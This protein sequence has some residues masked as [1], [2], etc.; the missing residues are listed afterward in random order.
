MRIFSALIL[1]T[2]LMSSAAAD[3]ASSPIVDASDADVASTFDY[4]A[5]TDASLN[6][7]LDG[8]EVQAIASGQY[9]NLYMAEAEDGGA[10]G[11]ETGTERMIKAG[12]THGFN[13]GRVDAHAPIGVM[14]E[15]VHK[16]GDFMLSYRFM[17]MQMEGNREG[18][19]RLSDQ[20]VRD[21][22]FPVVPTD[23][24]M[25][26]HMFGLMFA[27]TDDVTLMLMVPYVRL[28]MD[29][30]AG[31]TLGDVKFTTE[32]E[33]IGDIKLASLIKLY[34][35]DHRQ[36][37]INVGL[38]LPTGQINERGR[39][40]PPGNV[41]LPYP[42]QIG[43]G[44]VDLLLAGTYVY[45]QD[46]WSVGTQANGV[47]RLNENYR[48]YTLGNRFELTGWFQYQLL[49]QLSASLRLDYNLWG[50]IDGADPALNPAQVPTA[51]PGRRGGQRLDLLLGANWQ[52]TDGCLKGHRLAIEG[53]I[54]VWQ[55][56]DGPQL[57]VTWLM[58]VGWQFAF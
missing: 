40:T 28:A 45:Q 24:T 18:N 56:L 32:S 15:H 33:G 48:D 35:V 14:G 42:M 23:M 22:G 19:D 49:E 54:P 30:K 55:R 36:F 31:A 4:L 58:T 34:R 20:E 44:T 27:P 13:T 41:I 16:A 43:S 53:G 39:S 26:M 50:N 1:S 7:E 12:H 38:S 3:F 47:I 57:E 5:A 11:E 21:R 6:L 2:F 51:D 52:F 10:D 37:H 8:P 25:E 46:K 17:F 9:V 29:H